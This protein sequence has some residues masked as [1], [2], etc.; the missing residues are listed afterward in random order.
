MKDL[1]LKVM[2]AGLDQSDVSNIPCA[3]GN[4]DPTG[5][6]LVGGVLG[7]VYLAIGV[8]AVG[9]II[10]GGI[11]YVISEGEP[12]KTKKAQATITY[13]I[14]GLVVAMAATT[15]IGFVSGAFGGG[16]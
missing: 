6:G 3:G 2:A 13:T 10:F 15:I 11:Q 1:I 8:L 7:W 4:C 14:I 12:E 9:I 16:E 5:S